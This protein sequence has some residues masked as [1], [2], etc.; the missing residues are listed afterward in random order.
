[1]CV[2][3]SEAAYQNRRAFNMRELHTICRMGAIISGVMAP[4]SLAYGEWLTAGAFFIG[5]VG[6]AFAVYFSRRYA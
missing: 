6:W 4:L 3:R 1:M 2:R 5:T